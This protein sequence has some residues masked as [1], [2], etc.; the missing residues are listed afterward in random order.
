MLD[1]LQKKIACNCKVAGNW[2]SLK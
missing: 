1:F 2:P